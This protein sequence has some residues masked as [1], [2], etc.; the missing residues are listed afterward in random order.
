M[1]KCPIDGTLLSS[2]SVKLK[3]GEICGQCA[4]QVGLIPGSTFTQSHSKNYTVDEIISLMGL[5]KFV[6]S[7][8]K[9]D[10]QKKEVAAFGPSHSQQISKPDTPKLIHNSNEEDTRDNGWYK[11]FY[12]IVGTGVGI[13]VI[14]LV[15]GTV[16]FQI[17]QKAERASN[18]NT[19]VLIS[20]SSRD[21]SNPSASVDSSNEDKSDKSTKQTPQYVGISLTK[22]TEN[23]D[24]YIG[25]NIQT[26]GTVAYIQ[27]NPDDDTM[28][29][30]V[31]IPQ[32]EYDSSGY[33]TGH[34]T[35]TEMDVDTM[36]EN[37][38]HEGDTITVRGGAMT[39]TLKLNG[40]TL[41][42][43]IIVDSVSK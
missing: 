37:S 31:I 14:A 10:V 26:R 17:H 9:I 28:Y 22:F 34:G 33:S 25:K 35:V 6:T 13:L 11:R 38:I 5:N 36:K 7:V 12:T 40:K 41:N 42:S 21:E 39:D 3:D 24:N 29:Y 15:I 19:A 16:V 18:H 20:S 4:T 8:D 43:D 30:A 2:D 27:K 32:D 23:T 1:E